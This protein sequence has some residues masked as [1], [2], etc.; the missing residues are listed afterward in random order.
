MVHGQSLRLIFSEK[1]Q[2]A[3]KRSF[4]TAKYA[5]YANNRESFFAYFAV[6]RSGLLRLPIPRASGVDSLLAAQVHG[7]LPAVSFM[8]FAPIFLV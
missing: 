6:I 8:V 1:A 7:R 3:Q 5:K 2:K 4:F